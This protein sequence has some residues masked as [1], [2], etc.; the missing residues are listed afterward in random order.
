MLVDLKQKSQVTIPKKIVKKLNLKVGDKLD[1][2]E[3]EGSLIITPVVVV[4]K[5]QA[6]FFG[7]EWQ[8]SEKEVDEQIQKGEIY[9]SNTKEELFQDLGLDDL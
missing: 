1:V 7:K 3:E 5:N 4:P 6:W 8:K 2:E 9:T